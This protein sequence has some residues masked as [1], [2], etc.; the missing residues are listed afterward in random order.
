MTPEATR[1]VKAAHVPGMTTPE[2][3]LQLVTAL[4]QI[5]HDDA[6]AHPGGIAGLCL[7]VAA[8]IGHVLTARGVL[9][10]AVA[11]TLDGQGHW[12]LEV[13]ERIVDPTRHQFDDRHDLL[14]SIVEPG[15]VAE[16]YHPCAW[17]REQVIAEAQRA[18][19]FPDA[20]TTWARNLLHELD[21]VPDS[22][23]ARWSWCETAA[24]G[25]RSV[26]HVRALG[27]EETLKEGGGLRVGAVC[28][29]DLAGGWDVAETTRDEVLASAARTTETGRTCPRCADAL[30]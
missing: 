30:R 24:A 19:V 6:S 28:G 25:P 26:V 21:A 16:S 29:R 20:A 18:F 1:A 12:W 27:A 15:Y 11:G 4:A 5:A 23:R 10:I 22:D 8:A 3:D 9:A 2:T 13:G 17:T 7:P 14:Y